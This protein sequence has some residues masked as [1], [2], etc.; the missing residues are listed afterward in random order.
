MGLFMKNA[1]PLAA[2]II[3]GAMAYVFY[4]DRMIG[5]IQASDKTHK[6]IYERYAD[7]I[8]EQDWAE[9]DDKMVLVN[10][11]KNIR[12]FYIDQYEAT[13][14]NKRAWSVAGTT[15]TTKLTPVNASDACRAA[16]KR[17]CTTAEWRVGCRDGKTTPH[18]FKNTTSFLKYCD[19]GRSK[20]YDKNDYANKTDSHPSCTMPRL[21]LYHMV[22][23]VAEL[24][25]GPG[26]K[27][28]AVG[29]TYLGTTYYGAAFSG[30]PHG[31]MK[32]A[33]EYTITDNYPRS[34]HN[35]GMG[36]RCCRDVR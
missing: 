19:F 6:E 2:I 12:P 33:C 11:G 29:M 20:G 16:G 14:V 31:A 30:D 13:I 4:P 10:P 9:E 17:L 24:T 8:V 15:P 22:G 23:N 5:N 18:L 36:F 21:N 32:M 27:Y 26:G 28:A 25:Q 7:N 3:F 35:E 1:L 34:R